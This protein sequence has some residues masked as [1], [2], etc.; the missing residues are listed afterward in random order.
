MLEKGVEQVGALR[1]GQQGTG[2][3]VSEVV[4]IPTTAAV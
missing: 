1:F 3:C 2:H 4:D